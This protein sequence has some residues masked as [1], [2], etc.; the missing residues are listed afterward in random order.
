MAGKTGALVQM[1]MTPEFW[2][3]KSV[4]V[5]GHTGFKGGWLSLWLQQLGAHVHGYSL[6]AA[7]QPSLFVEARVCEGLTHVEGDIRDLSHL[8]A[9]MTSAQPEIIFHLAAQ[10][11]VRQSYLDPIETM[12][13]NVVGAMNVLE[14][15]RNTPSVKAVVMITSDKCYENR[16]WHW[17]YRENE[18]LGGRDPYSASKAC[19][20]IVTACWRDSFLARQAVSVASARAGNVIGGGDWAADRLIPD[21]L[22]AWESGL[23]LEVRNP[24]AVRPWQH[25][26]EALA[27][28]LLL[29]ENLYRGKSAEA[30]NFGPSDADMRPVGALLDGLAG[31][32]G[33]GAA[34]QA[35]AQQHPHEA[36]LLRLDS[37]KA[38]TLLG[39][40]TKLTIDQALEQ[41]I[42]WH[43]GW[44]AGEDMRAFTLNQ[45][46]QYMA[47]SQ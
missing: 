3:G 15:V 28:Y 32:W 24:Q 39:W 6:A 38:R 20:E 19:A 29:A 41:V 31:L 16:E 37:S 18:A 43:R 42:R 36:G 34:W 45:I 33:D 9:C 46:E 17:P 35:S 5:T 14:A 26:L 10:A 40:R 4:L 30:W 47:L 8:R 11:L 7:T 25:V 1:G 21:A 27:G 23:L 12:T 44:M 22:R 13:S 2:R